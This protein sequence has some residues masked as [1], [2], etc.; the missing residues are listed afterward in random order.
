MWALVYSSPSSFIHPP[1]HPHPSPPT[2]LLP[3]HP[4]HPR[5][6][7]LSFNVLPVQ[8]AID[9]LALSFNPKKPQEHFSLEL[10]AKRKPFGSSF[11]FTGFSSRYIGGGAALSHDH[12]TQFT[13]VYQSL[14]LW[15]EIMRH[16]PKLWLLADSDMLCESYRLCDT[17]QGYHRLQ[18][19]PQVGSEMRRILSHVQR[20]CGGQWVGLSVIH[21][22]DR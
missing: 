21:L 13:F 16:M 17:G 4:T 9:I 14:C 5:Q 18:S 7:Y 22:G 15:R 11:S 19:C 6:A 8:K 2:P 20:E 12:A 1:T 3:P 10:T